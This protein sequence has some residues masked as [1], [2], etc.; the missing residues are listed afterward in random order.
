M[1]TKAQLSYPTVLPTKQARSP[2]SK[3]C[4][5]STTKCLTRSTQQSFSLTR[6][7]MLISQQNWW[8]QSID[9]RVYNRV[10]MIFH[11]TALITIWIQCWQ[12]QRSFWKR[13]HVW[14]NVRCWLR[15]TL[16]IRS[17]LEMIL[18]YKARRIILHCKS[19]RWKMTSLPKTP[20]LITL[21]LTRIATTPYW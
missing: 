11:Q 3:S 21:S 12:W 17:D 15:S 13:L 16:R 14:A 19:T 7:V 9:I 8:K 18:W 6:S 1:W 2:R 5:H 20:S 4:N 10:R